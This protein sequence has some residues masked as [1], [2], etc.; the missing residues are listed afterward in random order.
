MAKR[1]PGDCQLSHN[2][3]LRFRMITLPC[4]LMLHQHNTVRVVDLNAQAAVINVLR[5]SGVFRICISKKTLLSR[6]GS[7]RG[8]RRWFFNLELGN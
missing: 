5:I 6:I 3:V 2:V 8:S 7:M 1:Q 4:T